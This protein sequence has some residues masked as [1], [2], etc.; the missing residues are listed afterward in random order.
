MKTTTDGLLAK[1]ADLFEKATTHQ[2]TKELCQG[3]LADRRLFIY[4]AQ[5][6]QFFEEGLRLMCKIA[7]LAPAPESLLTLAR[8]IGFFASD[9][10]GYFRDAL[11]LLEPQVDESSTHWV[12]N[13]LPQVE[14]Y[15]GQLIAMTRDQKWQYA[16]LIT[17]LWCA[18]IVYWQWAHYLPRSSNLHWKHQTWIDLHDGQHFQEWCD[19][20]RD[21]VNQFPLEEVESTFEKFLKLEYGFFESCYNA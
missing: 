17:Y 6:L 19:F 3:T 9:E 11:K 4:L 16:Q 12:S 15:V 5:D 7:S 2:L 10:N 14:S 18:E 20:L 21:E 1:Y 13:R 8:K